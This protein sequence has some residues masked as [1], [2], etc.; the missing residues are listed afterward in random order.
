MFNVNAV[1]SRFTVEHVSWILFS[2]ITDTRGFKNLSL[3]V[4]V[5]SE[6]Y[7]PSICNKV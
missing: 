1:S 3:S 5:A 2:H 6:L 4:S 7:F